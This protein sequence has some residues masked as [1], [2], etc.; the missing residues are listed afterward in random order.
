MRIPVNLST[1]PFRRDR[2]ILVAS[3]A[4]AV[5]LAGLLCLLIFLIVSERGRAKESRVAVDRLNSQLRSLS[6][7]QAKLDAFLHEPANAVVLERSMLLNEL[8]VRKS[9]SW[10]QIF[11]DLESVLPYN[12][13]LISV[14]LPQINSRNEVM[15]DMVVG[16][17][18]PDAVI[19]FFKK[20]EES[21]LFGPTELHSSIP[22]SQNQPLYQYRVTVN[23]AQKL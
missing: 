16:T 23:Y 15:L 17:K 1:Q 18:E 5:L 19:G 9:V 10:T 2:P 11:A 14:R 3:G 12:V 21:P 6:A 4:C 13:K 20:L 8:L 7:E 22:P